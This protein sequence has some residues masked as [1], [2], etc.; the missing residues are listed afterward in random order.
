M[1]ANRSKTRVKINVNDVFEEISDENKRLTKLVNILI[2]FKE[3]CDSIVSQLDA[4]DI[5]RYQDLKEKL[6]EVNE[7]EPNV[8]SNRE[9][10]RHVAVNRKQT[11]K[12]TGKRTFISDDIRL[13]IIKMMDKGGN[14]HDLG[15]KLGIIPSTITT[16]YNRYQTTGITY[17]KVCYWPRVFTKEQAEEIRQWYKDE[18]SLTL[19]DLKEKSVEKWP[20]ITDITTDAIRRCFT[21]VSNSDSD[22][23]SQTLDLNLDFGQYDDNESNE[24]ESSMAVQSITDNSSEMET[25]NESEVI[26]ESSVDQLVESETQDRS[27]K[28][29]QLSE[30]EEVSNDSEATESADDSEANDWVA[31]KSLKS[32][33]VVSPELRKWMIKMLDNGSTV[34]QVA[35]IIGKNPCTIRRIYRIYQETGISQ[36]RPTGKRALNDEQVKQVQQWF[37]DDPSLTLQELKN[38]ILDKYGVNVQSPTTILRYLKET[39]TKVKRVKKVRR[40]AINREHICQVCGKSFV[41]PSTL[42]IHEEV[43][44]PTDMYTCD[45]CPFTTKRRK[46]VQLHKDKMHGPDIRPFK[47]HVEGCDRAFRERGPLRNHLAAVHAPPENVVCHIEG[48]GRVLKNSSSF[49][50][51]LECSH[52]EANVCCEWPGCDYK[53]TQVGKLRNHR[54]VHTNERKFVCQWTQCGKQF[55][56]KIH[57]RN[58]HRIHTN[59]RNYV[60][61]WPGCNY[62]CVFS[63]NLNKH[64]RVHQK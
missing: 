56:T 2:Q 51:H 18:P 21:Y 5:Q 58:H 4:N 20:N 62:S 28:M 49:K 44:N 29:E 43:H 17:N 64:M 50:I 6:N 15:N 57:L 3:F 35:K 61:S 31:K 63:G 14:A 52:G 16:I 12:R 8:A 48:C 30:E 33:K 54:L 39:L 60:C 11:A 59:E 1:N 47:C 13:Y 37:T 24:A 26:N 34:A 38:K 42:A 25:H 45:L 9:K 40:R 19:N 22:P 10:T 41:T 53:T 36:R 32:R 7:S 46:N 27:V 23:M 55:K